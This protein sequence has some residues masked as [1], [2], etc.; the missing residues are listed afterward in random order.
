MT[1]VFS[2]EKHLQQLAAYIDPAAQALMW[3]DALQMSNIQTM[4]LVD[5]PDSLDQLQALLQTGTRRLAPMFYVQSPVYLTGKYQV[6]RCSRM[7][8]SLCFLSRILICKRNLM[9][10]LSI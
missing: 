8:I 1:Y 3:Q 10:W 6:S 4:V 2:K 9:R 7:S 5:L